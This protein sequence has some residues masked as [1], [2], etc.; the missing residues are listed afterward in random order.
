VGLAA[1]LTR[2]AE[3]LNPLHHRKQRRFRRQTIP[4]AH[5]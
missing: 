4:S 2:V 1:S 5:L 3:A